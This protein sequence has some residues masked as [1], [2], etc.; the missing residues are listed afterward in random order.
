MCVCVCVCVWGCVCLLGVGTATGVFQAKRD[1]IVAGVTRKG[2]I[3]KLYE[4]FS[5]AED[6]EEMPALVHLFEVSFFS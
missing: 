2:F 3:Q 4:I 6:L 5:T 1:I